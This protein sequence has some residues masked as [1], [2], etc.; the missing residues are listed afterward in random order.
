MKISLTRG[1]ARKVLLSLLALVAVLAVAAI[2]VRDNITRKLETISRLAQSYDGK[3]DPKDALLLLQ[4]AED[5]F[6]QSLVDLDSLKGVAYRT[7]LSLAF[8]AIETLIEQ[9]ADISQFGAEQRKQVQ[10]WHSKKILLSERLFVLKR[11]FDSLLIVHQEYQD[12]ADYKPVALATTKGISRK[13]VKKTDTVK[14]LVSPNKKGL[15]GR[16]KDA[17]VNKPNPATGIIEINHNNQTNVNEV[18]TGNISKSAD[19]AAKQKLQKLQQSYGNLLNTQRKLILLNSSITTELERIVN[20]LREINYQ[21]SGA[22]KDM[23]F[24]NYQEST[25]LLNGLYLVALFMVL[26]FALLLII[27]IVQLGKAELLLRKEND[28]AVTAARQKMDLLLQMSH[29]IRNPL[30]AIQ[31]FL[32][33]FGKTNLS[34]RQANMLNSIRSSSEMLLRTLNDTLDAAKMEES[35]L[36]I[37]PVL[38][39]AD[40]TIQQVIESMNYSADKKGLSMSY[41][42]VGNKESLL[43]GDDFRL[44]QIVVNLISNAIKYTEKGE[45]RIHAELQNEGLLQVD[46]TDTGQGI[47]ADQLPNLFS[48]YYQ[49]SSSKGQTG[50]GLGLFICKQLTEMQGGK[51]S[52]KSDQAKGTTFSFFIPYLKHESTEIKQPTDPLALLSGIHILAVDDNELNLVLLKAMTAKWNVHFHGALNAMEALRLLANTPVNIILTDL[53]MPEIDGFQ[54]LK[55][56]SRLPAPRNQVPVI[57][58]S[59][60]SD[61]QSNKQLEDSGFAGFV[62]KPFEEDELAEALM[63]ALKNR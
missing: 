9:S 20:E 57:A 42:F 21:V 11:S 14:K 53:Q 61:D 60:L 41:N 4:Q 48:K 8:N 35:E 18:R 43:I 17:I 34:E 5:D 28:R 22:L 62:S 52:V 30:T 46:V 55:A 27:F 59:G 56:I 3:V 51:I 50:T 2:I 38:F 31:G 7:K 26:L 39:N 12:K 36:K 25:R 15:F 40:F 54:L 37:N 19:Q 24:R 29:E 58:V 6:Q 1:L 10:S 45:I 32:F 13:T 23:S 33:I 16:I 63:K 44:K 47:P 49:T